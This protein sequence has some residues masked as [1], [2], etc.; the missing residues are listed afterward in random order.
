[1]GTAWAQDDTAPT[2]IIPS[3]TVGDKK[4]RA[5]SAADPALCVWPPNVKYW[6][7]NNI[8]AQAGSGSGGGRFDQTGIL[9]VRDNCAA[10]TGFKMTVGTTARA[11]S[12]ADL[13]LTK[14]FS[15]T[16]TDPRSQPGA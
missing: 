1:M 4:L 2:Y 9:P 6:C 12:V 3:G 7:L 11:A 14:G 10:V 15:C 8:F 16:D 13:S 5:D